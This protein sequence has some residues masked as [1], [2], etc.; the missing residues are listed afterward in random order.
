M[1]KKITEKIYKMISSVALSVA[2]LSLAERNTFC[3]LIIHQPNIPKRLREKAWLT[4]E[5]QN[6][7]IDV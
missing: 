4:P 6:E 7:S 1:M 2:V 5:E 3:I